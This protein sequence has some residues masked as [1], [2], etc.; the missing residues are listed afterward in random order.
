MR[1][2]YLA[3][4]AEGR[5]RRGMALADDVAALEQRLRAQALFL[6]RCTPKPL[7]RRK[8]GRSALL[9]F[10]RQMA[11]LLAAGIPL[12]EALA[13]LAHDARDPALTA[14]LE[15]TQ[16][17]LQAGQRLSEALADTP[18]FAGIPHA[19]L[20]AGETAGRLP[21]AFLRLAEAQESAESLA[22][23]LHKLLL[24]PAIAGTVVLG[25]AAFLLFYLVPQLAPFITQLGGELPWHSKALFG[26][27]ELLCAHAL[28]VVLGVGTLGLGAAFALPRLARQ[29]AIARGLLRLPVYGPWRQKLEI[30]R[31]SAALALLYESGLGVHDALPLAR[32]LVGN[33]ALGAALTQIERRII[34]DG[35]PL[36]EAFAASPFVPPL[37]TRMIRV[38][39]RTGRLDTALAHVAHHYTRE[40][41]HTAEQAVALLEPALTLFLGLVLGWL[42]L[43]VLGPIYELVARL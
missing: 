7:R 24:Y 31:F 30:A 33:V 14:F 43:S 10:S 39:E 36:A 11:A 1:F 22:T 13:D 25:A 17:R 32:G 34:D 42:M 23:R 28:A 8:L 3:I 6:A 38:A 18:E 41:A 16:A 2:S 35:T 12:A 37:A 20:T 5:R 21:E 27:S 15:D 29:A 4:D 26:L 9:H 19:A 40:T